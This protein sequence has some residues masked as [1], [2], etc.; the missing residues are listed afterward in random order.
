MSR[1]DYERFAKFLGAAFAM[2]YNHG[3]EESRTL[4][5]ETVYS[6]LVRYLAE[7]NPN[8]DMSRFSYAV[9]VEE[10]KQLDEVKG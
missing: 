9:A 10:G 2:A 6:P 5:Y 1:K 4:I 3:G 8:F 7:D